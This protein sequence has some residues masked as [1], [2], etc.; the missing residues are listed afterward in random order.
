MTLRVARRLVVALVG[1]TLLLVGVALL[2]LPGPGMLVI[3][4][5]LAALSTEFVW[6]RRWLRRIRATADEYNPL[7][8]DVSPPSHDARPPDPKG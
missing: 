7:R 3:G 8:G 2:V 1:A 6:A 5:G 4:I